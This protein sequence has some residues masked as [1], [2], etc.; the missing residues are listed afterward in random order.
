MTIPLQ[1]DMVKYKEL[2][3]TEPGNFLLCYAIFS[4]NYSP[5]KYKCVL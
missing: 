3:L 2:H 5:R 4:E 1:T